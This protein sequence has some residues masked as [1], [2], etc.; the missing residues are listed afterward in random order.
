MATKSMSYDHPQYTV[1]MSNSFA[2]A[3]GANAVSVNK[4]VA[5]TTVLIKSLTAVV[6]TAGTSAAAGNGVIVKG[7]YGNGTATTALATLT[8]GTGTAATAT[9]VAV[10]GTLTQGES[11]TFT[12][13]TDATGAALVCVEYI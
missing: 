10:S 11:L 9:N 2:C 12:N 6:V 7:I 13:G 4:F 5:Y 1:A 3:A 8:L